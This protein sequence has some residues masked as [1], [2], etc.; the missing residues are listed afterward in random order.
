MKVCDV[1][2]NSVWHDPRVTKQV[3]EYV[4]LGTQVSCV[5]MIDK[6]YDADRVSGMPCPVVLVE[7]DA[8]FGGNGWART[9]DPLH[10]KQVL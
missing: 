4:R 9:T 5:G 6:R 7:R 8:F 10:V 2:L 3:A 1:V